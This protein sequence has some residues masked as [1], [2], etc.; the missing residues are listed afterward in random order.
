[1]GSQSPFDACAAY[2]L[3]AIEKDKNISQIQSTRLTWSTARVNLTLADEVQ[4]AFRQEMPACENWTNV[5]I[6]SV[7]LRI[8]AKSSGR[9]FVGPELCQS[10]DYLEAAIKYTVEVIGAANAVSGVPPWLRPLKASRLPEVRRLL[11]RRKHAIKFMQPVV[12]SRKALD[13][14]PDDLLQWLIDN[15]G[16]LGN[17]TTRMLARSQLALSF[18]AI[19]K[20]SEFY[21]VL[22]SLWWNQNLAQCITTADLSICSVCCQ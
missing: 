15:D 7:L 3:L 17:M 18:A 13:Q 9:I 21:P 2:V 8:V 1:M 6:N 12:E 19:R 22:E 4:A 20:L 11:E 5:K 14:K 10:E 16:H